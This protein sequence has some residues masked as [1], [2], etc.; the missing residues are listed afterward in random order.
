MSSVALGAPLE[1]PQ[2]G[3]AGLKHLRHDIL[4]GIV[5]SLVSLP[6]SSGIAI[7]SGVP[8]IYGLIS[9]I[10][11]GLLFP[12]IGG[13]YMT[14]SGPAAGLAPALMMVMISLGGAGDAEHLGPGYH[15]LLV[16]IFM[17]G[18]VQLVLALLKLA[19][20]AAIIPV[21]V[22]EGMLCSIGCLI[23]VKQLPM[24]FGYTGKVHAHE[25]IEFVMEG[26]HFAQHLTPLPFAI[27]AVSLVLLFVLGALAKK[28]RF[29]QIVPPQLL[30]VI[31]GTIIGAVMNLGAQNDGKFLI[32]LPDTPFHGPSL[33]DF[34]GLLARQ[35]LWYAAIMGV[36]MLTMIDGVESLATAF[37]IDRID[38]YRRK[39]EPNRV[40]LAMG[41]SNIASSMVGGLT[42]IPGGVKS[43]VN[44]AS[45]G[46]T[47]WA[48]FTNA[49]C[50]I[51]YLMV[52]QQWINMI[53]KGVLAAVLIF[54]GW[55]M[56]EPLVWRGI[57][58]IGKEQLGL[59]AFTVLV[60][61]LTDLLIGIVAGVVAKFFLNL[62]LT[63]RSVAA[64]GGLGS[65]W[66]NMLGFFRNPITRRTL[67]NGELHLYIDRPLVCFNSM[68]L[69]E[70]LTRLPA[71]AKSVFVHLNPGV[72]LID[73]TSCEVL[74]HAVEASDH[75]EIPVTL[76]GMD[77]MLRLSKHSS[78]VH[79]AGNASPVP[80]AV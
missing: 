68:K 5:V 12:L 33:P 69:Q 74:H 28:V 7:A 37:A 47:L 41:I 26:P 75:G 57:A 79:V 71:E 39:S 2:N 64:A 17:V 4:S 35:D 66:S 65:W 34:A 43:K 60:T 46:R 25:F 67:E 13:A 73:H 23:I 44:I 51:I 11:A 22:V 24:F 55:K 50:L 15:H 63:S 18:C 80:Q 27:A 45:G 3:I 38:P 42:I 52:G 29:F 49:I 8:P 32:K 53:P 10:I 9:A 76:I 70:E 20:F 58:R 72:T 40:L 21:S 36:I 30:A 54:T 14:I 62:L 48:N 16:V 61:L 1:Q 77:R 31:V 56:C 78:S 59:F 6:L 19:R